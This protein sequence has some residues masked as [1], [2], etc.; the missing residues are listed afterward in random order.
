[1]RT[2]KRRLDMPRPNMYRPMPLTPCSALSV[3]LTRDMSRPMAR[4]TRAAARTP[5]QRLPVVRAT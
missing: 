1:M 3:T 5:S 4:P 2:L